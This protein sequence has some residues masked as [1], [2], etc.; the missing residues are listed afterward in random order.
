MT[1]TA[2]AILSAL[3]LCAQ[4]AKFPTAIATDADLLVAR[5]RA[6]STLSAAIATVTQTSISVANGAS[7]VSNM[8]VTIS[9]SERVKLCN[10]VGNTLTVGHTSCPNVD[11]RGFDGSTA[12]THGVGASARAQVTAWHHN[13]LRAEVKAL[14][15]NLADSR[16][17]NFPA[18]TPG[19]T[20]TASVPA[21][22]TL[23]PCP[24][25]VAGTNTNHYLY[26]SG[27]VG[28]AEAVLITGGT[29]TSG[30]VTGTITFTPGNNHSGAWAI[31][32]ATAGGQEAHNVLGAAGGTVQFPPGEFEFYAPLT[33]SNPVYIEGVGM[34]ATILH[35]NDT[36]SHIVNIVV[37]NAGVRRLKLDK[38]AGVGARTA[39][40]ITS[41]GAIVM[42][43]IEE[44]WVRNQSTGLNLVGA[45]TIVKSTADTN[46]TG[47]KVNGNE[48]R[49]IATQS[50]GNTT[51]GFYLATGTGYHFTETTAASNGVSNYY[52]S[53][54]VRVWRAYGL[55]SSLTTSGPGID[56]SA[57]APL[58]RISFTNIYVETSGA[59]GP[60]SDQPGIKINAVTGFQVQGGVIGSS[61]GPGIVLASGAGTA[62]EINITGVEF[63][64]N[65]SSVTLP[66]DDTGIKCAGNCG[67]VN[68][69]GNLF[70]GDLHALN[71]STAMRNNGFIFTNNYI[72]GTGDPI[73]G[74]LT[75]ANRAL[76]I[77]PNYWSD[78]AIPTYASG[79]TVNLKAHETIAIITG[80]VT[81]TTLGLETWV[82]RE[83]TLI[84]TGTAHDGV[85]T[86]GN[87]ART[88]A[89]VQNQAITL[90]SDGTTWY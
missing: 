23:T 5:D 36:S 32:S 39:H 86:G 42:G 89:V 76:K 10:V 62:S 13:A 9:G 52:A 21:T 73:V 24:L 69:S 67:W 22:V 37:S 31:A 68:I 72:D 78:T 20:L 56:L 90:R 88:Q 41:S 26:V 45:W 2:L 57:A 61:T 66:D 63:T 74:S 19:G 79:A 49:V 64:V 27:G 14:A 47:I 60:T 65:G 43:V 28:T 87:I 81:I 12:S 48:T 7:L 59:G 82:G 80:T 34:A 83:A 71:V 8:V 84:F 11:G 29:C 54:D 77:Q 16:A 85:G 70:K 38:H 4:T 30:A 55:V 1:K 25:G 35:A 58:E 53:G 50:N 33:I 46:A 17:Y 40:G 44:V 3:V 6:S 18:Q 51:Y 75:V 15:A